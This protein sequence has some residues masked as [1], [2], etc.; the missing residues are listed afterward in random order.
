MLTKEQKRKW[1]ERL[2]DPNSKQLRNG[3]TIN[4]TSPS[5]PM[6]CL[7]HGQYAIT[8]SINL[9]GAFDIIREMNNINRKDVLV[10]MNDHEYKSLAQIAD[11]IEANVPCSDT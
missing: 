9:H 4:Y 6:C 7:A 5:D 2:R 1:L 8:G 10:Q 11:Y 3:Y